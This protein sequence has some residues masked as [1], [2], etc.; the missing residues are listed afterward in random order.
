MVLERG[1]FLLLWGCTE[2]AGRAGE[3]EL[4]SRIYHDVK[5]KDKQAAVYGRRFKGAVY[6][7]LCSCSRKHTAQ[8]DFLLSDSL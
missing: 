5:L 4:L 2:G 3:Y 8:E 6:E 7:Q 1:D